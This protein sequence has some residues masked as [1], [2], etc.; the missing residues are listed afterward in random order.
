MK[1]FMRCVAAVASLGVVAALLSTSAIAQ[2]PASHGTI[3]PLYAKGRV[4][5]LGV[6]ETQAKVDGTGDTMIF[7]VSDPTLELFRPAPGRANGTAVIIAPGGGFVGLD[8]HAGGTAIARQL[9]RH[10]V[11]ARCSSTAPYAARTT[12]RTCPQST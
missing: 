12:P 4:H 6:P 9:V 8:Y 5:S 1:K 3:I 2:T 11:T 7:N 10:G